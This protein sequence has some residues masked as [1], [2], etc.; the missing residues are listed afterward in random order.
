LPRRRVE[1][2]FREDE[3]DPRLRSLIADIVSAAE[4]LQFDVGASWHSHPAAHAAFRS[5]LLAL[6]GE[7][8]PEG[9]P[10]FGAV[11]D[12]LGANISKSDDPDTVGR[13]LVR[14]MKRLKAEREKL[15]A[16]LRERQEGKQ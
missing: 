8:R 4:L 16:E 6:L 2:T 10:V 7:W 1:R 12:L 13:A 15:L 11:R 14:Q 5:A 3:I 9:A